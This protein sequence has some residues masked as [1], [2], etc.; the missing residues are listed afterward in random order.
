MTKNARMKQRSA[1]ASK[2][3]RAVLDISLLRINAKRTVAERI[4]A[5]DRALETA[6]ALREAVK[7]A[8]RV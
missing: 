2:A 8:A 6:L 7:K 3:R 1:K 5:H 4:E